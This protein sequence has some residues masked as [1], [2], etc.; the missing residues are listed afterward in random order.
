MLYQSTRNDS[1]LLTGTQAILE[2]LAEDGGLFVP[3]GGS[4]PALDYRSLIHL[5]SL[6]IAAHILHALLPEF[7]EE[8]ALSLAHAAYDGK[9]AAEDLTPVVKVGGDYILELFHGPTSAFK[10]VALCMLPQLIR[11]S[12]KKNGV[13]DKILI[14][15]ATSGDTGKAALEGFKDVEGTGIIVYYPD[16]GVS[17]V[18]KAQMATQEGRNVSVIAVRGNFD[19]CQSGVKKIFAEAEASHLTDGRGVRLSSANSINIGRLIPQIIYYYKAYGKVVEGGGIR[20]GDK[21]DFSVPTG[22]FGD[23]FAGYL[24]KEM[25]LPVGRLICASNK[26]NVLTDFFRTGVYNRNR[27]FYKTISP[28]MDILISSNLERLLYFITRDAAAVKTM[29]ASLASEGTYTL[30]EA[31]MND[32]RASFSADFATDEEA[33]QSIG[34]LW[35]TE[36]Y[37]MDPHTAAAYTAAKRYH[38]VGSDRPIVV[39]STASI[40]KF[41]SAVVTAIGGAISGAIGGTPSENEFETMRRLHEMSGVPIPKGL[42]GLETRRVL[43]DTVIEKSEMLQSV[44]DRM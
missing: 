44:I 15:T 13:T 7:S 38:E 20:L 18:Q 1:I 42:A 2:G 27:P 17:A 43:H 39:L 23:I 26:N 40:Y 16:G 11:A 41:P 33:M 24:A 28:S 22:N 21:L 12:L 29:M 30:S 10:D 3:R 32:I 14:L 37:L 6:E 34:E 25:G 35:Q 31:T 5:S 8:E 19:D 4:L 9:F 36:H